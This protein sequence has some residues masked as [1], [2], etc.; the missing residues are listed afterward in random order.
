[1]S[2]DRRIKTGGRTSKEVRPPVEGVQIVALLPG[3]SLV[4]QD[5]VDRHG[6]LIDVAGGRPVV[7]NF[8]TEH[9]VRES[10]DVH[11]AGDFVV[12]RAVL[13]PP[14]AT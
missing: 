4:G 8:R 1:M 11:A 14:F 5:R 10:L 2:G 3:V 7:T 9:Q 13:L 6:G 12:R